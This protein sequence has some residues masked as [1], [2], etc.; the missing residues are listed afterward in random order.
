MNIPVLKS[1]SEN[2]EFFYALILILLIPGAF[3]LNTFLFVR[4]LNSAFETELTSKANLAT[5]IIAST[6]SDSFEDRPKLERAINELTEDSPEI[7]G[8]TI[9]SFEKGI[10]I[11]LATNEGDDAL[12]NE[13]V[14]LTKLA[15][16]TQQPYTT[17]IETLNENAETIRIWQVALPVTQDVSQDVEKNK[18]GENVK[19][20][21]TM[22]SE[23]LKSIG[24]INL[25]VSGEKSDIII[26]KLERDSV[27]FTLITLLVLVL[28][29]LNHFRFFGYARLFQKLKEVDEMKDNFISLAS[30]ELRTPVTALRGFASLA[31][32][33]NTKGSFASRN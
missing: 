17:K 1:L 12:S 10:P 18:T 28:L 31:R 2:K 29:L 11:V 22:A 26:N 6:L 9:I 19:A 20:E 23:D 14:L 15:W 25:K 4:G 33:E 16:T 30:H 13:S 3:I 24:V 32:Q 8:L 21:E 7:T 27:I 5:S